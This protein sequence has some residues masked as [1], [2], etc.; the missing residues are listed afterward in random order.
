MNDRFWRKNRRIEGFWYN[1][2][3]LV[4]NPCLAGNSNSEKPVNTYPET[5]SWGTV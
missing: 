3:I 4:C 1:P 5:V 2:V